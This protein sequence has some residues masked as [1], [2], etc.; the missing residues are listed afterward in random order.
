MLISECITTR[1]EIT[2]LKV[3]DNGLVA[4][5]TKLHGARLFS[6]EDSE[7]ILSLKS[8]YLNSDTSCI[9]FSNDAKHL[10][11][12]YEDF[13]YIFH[14]PSNELVKKISTNNEEVNI[15]TF[16]LSSLYIIAGTKSGR[17][18]Q[19]RFNEISLLSRICSFK[20]NKKKF[21]SAFAFNE[22]KI[23][24]SGHGGSII[25]LNLQSLSNKRTLTHGIS[26][27]NSLCFADNNTI[28][29]GN[30]DGI[31]HISSI[32]DEEFHKRISAPFRK[33]KQ[34]ILMP[35]PEYAMIS[36]DSKSVAII[37][38]K[39][40][41]VSRSNYIEF[42]DEV[43]KISLLDDETLVV[44]LDNMKI[45]DVYLPS[46]S[47]LKSLVLHNSLDEAYKIIEK[48]PMLINSREHQELEQRFHKIYLATIKALIQNNKTQA[49]ELIDMF[50]DIPALKEKIRLLF[51]AF[52]HYPRFQ[53]HCLEEKLS[54]AYAMA[55]KF[56]ALQQTL[57]FKKLEKAWKSAFKNA[58]KYV[59]KGNLNDARFALSTY[60]TVLVKKEL[61]QL[62]LRNNNDFI[63]FLKELENKNFLL[64]EQL[65]K[66]YPIFNEIPTYIS[67]KNEAQHDL[68]K[69][70]KYVTK[71]DIESAE[72]YLEEIK[73]I[74]SLEKHYLSLN[75][76][77]KNIVRI[78]KLYEQNEF[79]S[80]YEMI[81]TY[82]YLA[83]TEFGL[84]LDKHWS[85]IIR[86]CENY[87]FKGKI[88][89]VKETLGELIHLSTRRDKIG[90]ILRLSFQS[91]IKILIVQKSF[92][93]AESVLYSYLDIF[94]LDQEIETLME[95]FEVKSSSKLAISDEQ[96]N[97]PSR[98]AWINLL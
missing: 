91:N 30:S 93:K 87:A 37:N 77:C 41:K 6:I 40:A 53:I 63:T 97:Q 42:E 4:Y 76:K 26:K 1:S 48:N 66:K 51:E 83:S 95:T 5:S 47:L 20:S 89:D 17:V 68:Q 62:I 94:G 58:Q 67:L 56:P 60:M 12:S 14:M 38:I 39:S 36:G 50:K 82:N 43:Q 85:K 72:K 21:V 59:L 98:D 29:S 65:V 80:C 69:A 81:D 8:Q 44:A 75:T 64:I 19:Y 70:Q 73:N 49:L 28:I 16:D 13:I 45:L 22:N 71:G 84:L 57:E 3:L 2:E 23:A 11:L 33:I 18:L 27:I 34:I 10:A 7:I 54:L 15:L 55:N 9:A 35:N 78:N 61:I 46:V 31:I 74:P 88:K 90:N 25:V 86:K 52:K 32:N 92:T 24:C 96:N 79:N